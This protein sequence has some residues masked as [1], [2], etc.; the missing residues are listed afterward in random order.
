MEGQQVDF[1]AEDMEELPVPVLVEDLVAVC[2]CSNVEMY[3][4]RNVEMSPSRNVEMFQNRN[5]K[6]FQNRNVEMFRNKNVE[7]FQ[8][9]NVEMSQNRNAEMSQNKNVVNS[10]VLFFGAKCALDL[11]ASRHLTLLHLIS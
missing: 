8:S 9:K 3:Q 7:T 4:N 11:L 6:M 2:R 5:A 1:Q 10:A